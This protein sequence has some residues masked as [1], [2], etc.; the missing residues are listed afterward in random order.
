VPAEVPA[1]ARIF[2]NYRTH[3]EPFGAAL[4]DHELSAAFGSDLVFRAPKSIR[5]GEDFAAGI[6]AA[7]RRCDA[8][9]VLIGPRWLTAASS[10]GSRL[11]DRDDDWVHREIAEAL[12]HDVRVVP[13]LLN[14]TLPKATDLPADIADLASRQYLHFHHRSSRHDVRRLIEDLTELVP[15]LA[16]ISPVP[17]RRRPRWPVLVVA[18]AVFL[19]LG[20]AALAYYLS[21]PD[22]PETG[23][24]GRPSAT[25]TGAVLSQ[26]RITLAGEDNA[27]LE[28]GMTG[29]QVPFSDLYFPRAPETNLALAPQGDAG[30]AAVAGQPGFPDC[31][32]ALRTRHDAFVTPEPGAWLCVRTNHANVAAVQILEISA[33]PQR[34]VL[35]VT[36]WRR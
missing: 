33:V 32:Q 19:A 28:K 22:R 27:Y 6:L 31:E 25:G 15:G 11:L 20:G 26:D 17:P 1:G 7:V 8:L 21:R 36:V 29:T 30:M 2:L 14:T 24:S 9:L 18:A 10:D 34:I 12:Q 23:L 3:D 13:V 16:A 35:A 4:I 5:L